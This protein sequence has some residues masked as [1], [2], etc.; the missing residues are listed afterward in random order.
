MDSGSDSIE[1]ESENADANVIDIAE[2]SMAQ[3]TEQMNQHGLTIPQSR[4]GDRKDG[5]KPGKPMKSNYR[6]FVI[7]N[8][9][10][11]CSPPT[12]TI[13]QITSAGASGSSFEQLISRT[14]FRSYCVLTPVA[15]LGSDGWAVVGRALGLG[16]VQEGRGEL[17]GGKGW[18]LIL[19]HKA[20][21]KVEVEAEVVVIV[22][23]N[24]RIQS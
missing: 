17:G 8:N 2:D 22:E 19:E 24:F 13:V 14:I 20:M 5:K 23:Q 1:G 16:E 21:V 6:V 15:M 9:L 4:K 7:V 12:L 10:L 11:L 18:G 3:I